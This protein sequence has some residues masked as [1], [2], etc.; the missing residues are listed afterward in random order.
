MLIYPQIGAVIMP[1]VLRNKN[2]Q[3]ESFHLEAPPRKK[4]EPMG[5]DNH[6]EIIE[7][8]TKTQSVDELQ[9]VLSSSDLGLIRVLEDLIDLLC[10]NHV[11]T[12]TD[13]PEAAQKK[14]TSRKS[15]RAGMD[16]IE[17]LISEDD[18]AIF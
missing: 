2:G 14:L 12:F 15:I 8:L 16:G 18:D 7:F 6:Q 3:I 5:P 9:Q 13:L 17:N 4:A 10:K 1:Y 11:I